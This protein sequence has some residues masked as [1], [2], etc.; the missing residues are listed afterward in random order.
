MTDRTL[1]FDLAHA[2]TWL[3]DNQWTCPKGLNPLLNLTDYYNL[4][5]KNDA[6][7]VLALRSWPDQAIINY[8]RREGLSP[9]AQEHLADLLRTAENHNI[10]SHVLS[11]LRQT[12]CDSPA[13]REPLT[14]IA[15]DNNRQPRLRI[16]ATER[17]ASVEPATD[18][19]L[20]LAAN[21]EP[22]IRDH[23]FRHLVKQQHRETIQRALATLTD[24]ALR[25]GE[26]QIPDSTPLDWIA[27]IS[28][29]FAINNL[30]TLRNRTLNLNLWRVTTLVTSTIAKINKTQGATISRQ[31]LAQT[32]PTWQQR[33]RQEAENLERA[34]RIEA[35]QQTPFD[36][37]IRKLKGATSM[38][39]IKVWCEGPT[40]RPIFGALFTELGEPEIAE[41]LDSVGGW[42]HLIAKKEPERWYD[43]CR[44]AVIIMDGDV[45]RKL[46]KDNRPL[47]EPAKQLEKRFANHPITLHVLQRYGIENYLPQQACETVLGRDLTL[48]FPIPH[49]RKIEEHFCETQPFWRRWLNRLRWQKQPSFYHKNLN[50]KVAKH[51]AMADIQ[52]TDLAA[53]LADIKQR[54]QESRQF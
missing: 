47:T 53:I 51:L 49:Y 46:R 38:I 1:G 48:Y 21:E 3:G 41:T 7:I 27:S 40:D 42:P 12:G 54:A 29:A 24:D 50:E 43:G 30:R 39:R 45:G 17:L 33:Y 13:I 31:Q 32:P 2:I 26:V 18:T 23:A 4:R 28:A 6:P 52:G 20:I 25:A 8:Y 35:V 9:A 34:A 19:F 37:V 11:F 22:T 15:L 36:Q 10:T 44:Q 5:L 16:D 14:Q